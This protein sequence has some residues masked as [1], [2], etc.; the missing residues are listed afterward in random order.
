MPS[1]LPQLLKVTKPQ[2]TSESGNNDE[3][4]HSPHLSTPDDSHSNPTP[5][6]TEPPARPI[7]DPVRP[8]DTEGEAG[9]DD[10]PAHYP[11]PGFGL[12]RT[13]PPEQ[14]DISWLVDDNYE[15]Y[16]HIYQTDSQS[17]NQ[18]LL[19]GGSQAIDMAAKGKGKANGSV[20]GSVNGYEDVHM[21]EVEPIELKGNVKS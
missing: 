10:P 19:G 12:A 14:D 2:A 11:K 18:A 17:A 9:Y 13:L 15:V 5:P 20:D 21:A 16:S 6:P 4:S 7:H 3:A 1:S 8:D